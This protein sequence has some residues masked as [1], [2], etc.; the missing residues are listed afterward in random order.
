MQESGQTIRSDIVGVSREVEEKA[1]LYQ[2][3]KAAFDRFFGAAVALRAVPA[4]FIIDS[5]GNLL[6]AASDGPPYRAPP[7]ADIAR[8]SEGRIVPGELGFSRTASR[9]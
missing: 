2:E 3:D 5:K 8:A 1:S 4:A 7:L 9:L 6:A